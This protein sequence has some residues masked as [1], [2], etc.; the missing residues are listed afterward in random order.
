MTAT[1]TAEQKLTPR[2]TGCW[3][4]NVAAGYA[5]AVNR[6][7]GHVRDVLDHLEYNRI[8]PAQDS[9]NK[10]RSCMSEANVWFNQANN[11]Q[12]RIGALVT[13]VKAHRAGQA[14]TY[15]NGGD[16][17]SEDWRAQP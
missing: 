9:M 8:A 15:A 3:S 4:F 7:K 16:P 5:D 14:I 17:V 10:A 11:Q 12:W 13:E 2:E 1:E 6:W